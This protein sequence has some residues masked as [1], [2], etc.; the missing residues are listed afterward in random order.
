ME[1]KAIE[2]HADE[3]IEAVRYIDSN[4][5]RPD[6]LSLVSQEQVA[7]YFTIRNSFSSTRKNRDELKKDCAELDKL[8]GRLFK[9]GENDYSRHLKTFCNYFKEYY[10]NADDADYLHFQRCLTK[11][12]WRSST[13]KQK[14]NDENNRRQEDARRR[15]QEEQRR[16]DEEQRRRD[17]EQRRKNQ[18]QEEDRIER[19]R[20]QQQRENEERI[21]RQYKKRRWK[22]VKWVIFLFFGLPLLLSLFS[23]FYTPY[24]IDKKA[25][26]SYVFATNLFL[27]STK[28][29]DVEYNQIA[30]IPYGSELIT[31]GAE[32]GWTEVKVDDQKGFVSSDFILNSVDFHLLNGIWGNDITKEAISTAKCRLALLDYLKINKLKSGTTEWQ[33]YTKPADVKPNNILYPRLTNGYDTFTEFAFIVKN[34]TTGKR[35]LAIYSFTEDEKPVFSYQEEAPADGEIKNITYWREKYRVTY[36][37]NNASSKTNSVKTDNEQVKEKTK[38]FPIKINHVL[39]ANAEKSNNLLTPFGEKIYDDCQFLYPRIVFDN[40]TSESQK[41]TLFVKI[42][43]P[44]GALGV[45]SKSPAGYT[46]SF[47]IDASGNYAKGESQSVLSWGSSS[48]TSYPAGVYRFEIWIENHLLYKTSITIYSK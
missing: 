25:P 15:Q 6:L 42:Y 41:I 39:F 34:S 29:A 18:Q 11:K 46:Y 16:R 1:Q 28:A 10:L 23:Y 31:Y 40:L 43:N 22:V 12:G 5:N 8:V 4:C 24:S 44:G 3:W 9:K 35:F 38:E 14:Q 37:K 33:I 21:K 19:L 47:K 36:T 26:R 17:E 2:G 45:G 20:Q 48:G 13:D 7:N 30:K 27:R 32:G